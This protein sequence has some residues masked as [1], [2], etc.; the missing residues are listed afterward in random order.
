MGIIAGLHGFRFEQSTTSPGSTTFIQDEE[1][2]G[3]GWF[4]MNEWLLGGGLV[5][6]FEKFNQDLK[7]RV[8]QQSS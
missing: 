6:E 3:A 8:E 7:A 4:L 5:K 2:S 1:F